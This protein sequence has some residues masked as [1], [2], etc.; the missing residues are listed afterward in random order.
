MQKGLL[1]TAYFLLPTSYWPV[2]PKVMP[3]LLVIT[4]DRTLPTLLR[5]WR[6]SAASR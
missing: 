1:F 5:L 6:L 3:Q 2:V 4:F